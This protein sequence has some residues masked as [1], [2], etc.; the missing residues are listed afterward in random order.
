[1]RRPQRGIR[2]HNNC[3]TCILATS[4]RIVL[5]SVALNLVSTHESHYTSS[6]FLRRATH[7][8]NPSAL[9]LVRPTILLLIFSVLDNVENISFVDII[10]LELPSRA[11]YSIVH[12]KVILVPTSSGRLKVFPH[13]FEDIINSLIS[14]EAV[15]SESFLFVSYAKFDRNVIVDGSHLLKC[16][17]WTGWFGR[18]DKS[19]FC[20]DGSFGRLCYESA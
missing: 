13:A 2:W 1:L 11:Q 15:G 5:I 19:W 18:L 14:S 4:K 8:L 16:I 9:T 12:T 10:V 3:T 6:H 7:F 20:L 17:L